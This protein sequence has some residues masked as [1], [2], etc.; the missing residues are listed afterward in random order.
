MVSISTYIPGVSGTSIGWTTN[1]NTPAMLDETKGDERAL[2]RTRS[3][4]TR[5]CALKER[6]MYSDFQLEAQGYLEQPG[7]PQQLPDT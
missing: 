4:A 1:G 2:G 5:L 6:K 7:G 3:Q